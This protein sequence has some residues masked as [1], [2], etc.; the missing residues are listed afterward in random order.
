MSDIEQSLRQVKPQ[1]GGSAELIR[2]VSV[3]L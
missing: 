2:H 3:D 1:V